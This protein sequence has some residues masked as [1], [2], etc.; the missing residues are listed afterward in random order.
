MAGDPL[1][2]QGRLAAVDEDGVGQALGKRADLFGQRPAAQQQCAFDRPQAPGLPA[3]QAYRR[4]QA[5]GPDH[6][7]ADGRIGEVDITVRHGTH[8]G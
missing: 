8:S 7:P 4:G 3:L 5:E 1:G 6:A 2:G